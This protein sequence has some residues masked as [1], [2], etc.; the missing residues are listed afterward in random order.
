[1]LPNHR[2]G[3]K[4]YSIEYMLL[5]YPEAEFGAFKYVV[6]SR[7]TEHMSTSFYPQNRE[8]GRACLF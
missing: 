5:G 8:P 2:P 7:S 3:G 6:R 1:M 4:D